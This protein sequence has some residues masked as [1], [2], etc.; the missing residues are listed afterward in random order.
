[1]SNI[2][3]MDGAGYQ[4]NTKRGNMMKTL[5]NDKYKILKFLY[6]KK[7]EVSDH[8][9]TIT[10]QDTIAQNLNFSKSKVNKIMN[11]LLSLNYLDHS[12]K[13]KGSYR[14]TNKAITLIEIIEDIEGH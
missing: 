9:I 12:Y 11:E 8:Y 13:I 5:L 10:T 14:L 1:M 7:I 6:D 2:I 4:N 3:K